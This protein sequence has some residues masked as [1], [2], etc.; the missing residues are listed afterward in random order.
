[1]WWIYSCIHTKPLFSS[2]AY[3]RTLR[4]LSAVLFFVLL[5]WR[6]CPA[7]CANFISHSWFFKYTVTY[8]EVA[9]SV[10]PTWFSQAGGA[11]VI[12]RWDR[13]LSVTWTQNLSVTVVIVILSFLKYWMCRKDF[14]NIK[15]FFKL[16]CDINQVF[17]VWCCLGVSEVASFMHPHESLFMMVLFCDVF[18]LTSCCFSFSYP[19]LLSTLSYVFLHSFHPSASHLFVFT[20]QYFLSIT[21]HPPSLTCPTPASFPFFLCP[22]SS[23]C[24]PSSV[25]LHPSV[26]LPSSSFILSSLHPVSLYLPL[27]LLITFLLFISLTFC[28]SI[29]SFFQKVIC[30]WSCIL[31]L[32]V[33]TSSSERVL[34][35]YLRRAILTCFVRGKCSCS[36]N[37]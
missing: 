5:Q 29:T 16:H 18:H 4:V 3:F 35:H 9:R 15:E 13:R 2:H 7:L 23:F 11:S 12:L 8:I 22:C 33:S 25:C 26:C 31:Q 36:G 30:A 17:P 14:I 10:C 20:S 6:L 24:P 34:K 37:R 21:L 28:L 27:L 32:L 1:M 19:N